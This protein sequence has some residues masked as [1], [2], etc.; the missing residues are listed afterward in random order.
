MGSAIKAVAVRP[1]IAAKI[2]A[3]GSGVRTMDFARE[4]KG[5]ICPRCVRPKVGES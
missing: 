1:P 2:V 4:T 5:H 3:F